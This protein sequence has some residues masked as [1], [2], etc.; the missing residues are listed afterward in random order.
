MS[1]WALRAARTAAR[2]IVLFG[3]WMLLVDNLHEPEL[4]TGAVAAV[5]T[6]ALGEVVFRARS[7]HVRITPGMLRRLH[8]PFVLLV[9]DTVRVIGALGARLLLGREV[10][11]CFRAVRYRATTPHAEDRGRRILTEWG[12]SL[13]ANRYVVGVDVD[14]G[15]LLVHELVPAS[16]PLDPL[17]LG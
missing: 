1:R 8:R 10:T 13:A 9:T 2:I 12:A 7:E 14:E 5:I 4:V 11:G 17:E 6:A 16:G 15:Y 3:L